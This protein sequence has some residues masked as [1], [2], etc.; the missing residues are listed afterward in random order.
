[1]GGK[2]DVMVLKGQQYQIREDSLLVSEEGIANYIAG[3]LALETGTYFAIS[4]ACIYE[5]KSG[6]F[7]EFRCHR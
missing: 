5:G 1:M 6:D 3:M 7:Y 4:Y 2:A